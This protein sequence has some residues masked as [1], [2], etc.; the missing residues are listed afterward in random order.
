MGNKG[1]II[2]LDFLLSV[3]LAVLALGLLLQ[4]FEVSAYSKK[5]QML[6]DELQAAGAAAAENLVTS[7]EIIC[8]VTDTDDNPLFNLPNCLSMN[9]KNNISKQNLGLSQEFGFQVLGD[10]RIETGAS[11]SSGIG[12]IYSET[13]T[14]MVSD[15][16]ISKASLEQCIYGT[17]SCPAWNEREITLKV[18]KK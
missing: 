2:S 9:K 15:G 14:V 6:F 18:W 11:P 17:G 7:N 1:Q 5:Q 16:D 12:N 10:A 4:A 13:R 3:A 8:R